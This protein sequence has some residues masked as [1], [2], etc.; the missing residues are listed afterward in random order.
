MAGL[1]GMK[2]LVHVGGLQVVGNRL[3]AHQRLDIYELVE[4]F[5]LERE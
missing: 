3:M 4:P 2:M 1:R 5:N